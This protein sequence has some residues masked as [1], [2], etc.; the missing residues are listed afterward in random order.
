[1]AM[2]IVDE[3]KLVFGKKNVS[4]YECLGQSCGL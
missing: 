2:L 3:R 4:V 1:M